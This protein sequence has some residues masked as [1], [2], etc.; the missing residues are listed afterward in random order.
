MVQD[1]ILKTILCGNE[2]KSPVILGSGTIGESKK[3]II[4]SLKNGAGGAV[5]RT[6]RVD[7]T[8]RKSFNPRYYIED[9]FMLNA[10]N[11]NLRPWDY[12][13]DC[14]DEIQNYGAF[15]VS[16]SARN[17]VDS[18]II[19]ERF[20]KNSPPMFYELNF[21]CSHSGKIYGRISYK[22]AEESL[23]NIKSIT[24]TPVFLK[25]SLDNLDLEKVKELEDNGLLDGYVLSNT[26]GPGL[27][28]DVRKK[29]PVLGS[30][31]GGLSGA[32]MKPL[33]LA[34]I[35]DLKKITK[36]PII[37]V[38]GIESA[39]DVLE[40]LILGCDAVQIY[41]K[42]HR[43]GLKVFSDLNEKLVEILNEMGETVESIKG[44]LKNET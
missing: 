23:R 14:V 6:I 21:S 1:N 8:K 42:A 12:W 36:K 29:R 33:V 44:S 7:N 41:T 43:E 28:I 32:A 15:F 35:Y 2:L 9:N 4:N 18:K 19:V 5:N 17:P 22:A 39:E 3:G 20:E 24:S 11:N 30:V 26:I 27:K 10:D 16:I 31:F 34:K 40:Y 25:L 37:G 13:V 38:G